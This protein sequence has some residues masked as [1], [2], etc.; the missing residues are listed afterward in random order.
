MSPLQ[1]EVEYLC[2]PAKPFLEEEHPLVRFDFALAGIDRLGVD[3]S[4]CVQVF[5][6][7]SQRRRGGQGLQVIHREA[8]PQVRLAGIHPPGIDLTAI[9]GVKA[10]VHLSPSQSLRLSFSASG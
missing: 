5:G 1:V 10:L 3:Q 6:G 7:R 4:I 2:S 8:I 9:L